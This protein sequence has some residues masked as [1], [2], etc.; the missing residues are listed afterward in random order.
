[1]IIRGEHIGLCVYRERNFMDCV[2][3]CD[4]MLEAHSQSRDETYTTRP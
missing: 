1:M 4:D 2:G 3:V